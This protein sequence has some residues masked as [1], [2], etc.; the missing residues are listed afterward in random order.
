MTVGYEAITGKRSSRADLVERIRRYQ[1]EPLIILLGRIAAI[2]ERSDLDEVTRQAGIASGFLAEPLRAL[3]RQAFVSFSVRGERPV[4][5]STLQV[6]NLM[7]VAFAELPIE[8]SRGDP[9]DLA[10]LG[11]AL[12]MMTDLMNSEPQPQPGTPEYRD[13]LFR[14]VFANGLFHA[15]DHDAHVLA[16]SHDLYLVDRPHL[17]GRPAYI[18]LPALVK[19]SI[20]LDVETLW[21]VFFALSASTMPQPA[22]GKPFPRPLLRSTYFTSAF[23][24][25]ETEVDRFLS[26]IAIDATTLKAELA[27][28]T[29]NGL[30]RYNVLPFLSRPL[31]QFGDRLVPVCPRFVMEKLGR[32]LHFIGL[33]PSL[34]KAERDKYLRYIGD[35]FEDDVHQLFERVFSNRYRRLDALKG[36]HED[37]I[38]DGLIVLG[39]AVVVVETKAKLFTVGVR[40]AKSQDEMDRK[41]DETVLRGARQIHATIE[42][43]RLGQ[44]DPCLKNTRRWYPL[45]V[46]LERMP[47]PPMIYDEMAR[48]IATESLLGGGDVAPYQV[49]EI[50]DL[51]FLEQSLLTGGMDLRR[52]LEQ[53]TQEPSARWETFGDYLH[54]RKEPTF[55]GGKNKRLHARFDEIATNATALY[56]ARAKEPAP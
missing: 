22:D 49:L 56:L 38:A 19:R 33:N 31:I 2:L 30:D 39:D 36:G 23:S 29:A 1:L 50:D 25:T 53:K 13:A 42:A 43:L 51:E 5:F 54:R 3:W 46:T 11:E 41:L 37:R 24:F 9:S 20:G 48:R 15:S 47:M 55:I 40:H 12:L 34:P 52:V 26:P 28:L 8:E 18:D 17:R 27:T 44:L 10:P 35:V 21:S 16:R 6:L 32:G 4:A 45:I 7:K 14:D